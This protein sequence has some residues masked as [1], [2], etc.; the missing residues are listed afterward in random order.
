MNELEHKE[1][2]AEFITELNRVN[3]EKW[4][5]IKI[6]DFVRV[7]YK[8]I[9]GHG[10]KHCLVS[11]IEAG[12]MWSQMPDGEKAS[13][14][15]FT[16]D[17]YDSFIDGDCME[18]TLLLSCDLIF[19]GYRHMDINDYWNYFKPRTMIK[20]CEVLQELEEKFNTLDY[21]VKN[22]KKTV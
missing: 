17:N 7:Y 14:F 16:P 4:E 21:G 19:D 1:D 15:E 22:E 12:F 11:V 5:H 3:T 6:D 8:M 20:I 9:N 10:Y 13:G 2:R 18:P